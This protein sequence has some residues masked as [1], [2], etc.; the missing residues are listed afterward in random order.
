MSGASRV[1]RAHAA[2]SLDAYAI[3]TT[4]MPQP[5]PGE[6]RLRVR[7][8]GVGYVD[9]LHATGRYQLANTLPFTPGV[10]V[11]GEI[12]AVGEGS[13]DLL[14]GMRVIPLVSVRGGFADHVLAPAAQIAPIPPAMD[15]AEAAAVRAN[16]LTAMHALIDRGG[17]CAGQTVLVFGAAGGVGSAAV[18]LAGRLGARVVAVGSTPEKREFAARLGAA[19]TIDTEPEGWRDRLAMACRGTGGP[20]IVVDPVCG[21]LFEAA[22]RS[23]GWGGRHLVIGFAGGP[24]PSLKANLSLLKGAAL[25]GVDVRQFGLKQPEDAEANRRKLR[26][27]MTEGSVSAAVSATFPF[28]RFR[29]ALEHAASGTGLGKTVLLMD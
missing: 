28:M 8:C 29:E 18:Q 3:E 1:I 11:A 4:S 25:V 9:A 10:E 20:D 17:L 15:F 16:W 19:A 2:R 6:V 12:D 5:G 27:W 7:A 24:I 23:I 14:P 13:G 26:A 22:F 21:P